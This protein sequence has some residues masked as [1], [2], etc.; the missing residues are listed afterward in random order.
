MANEF[1]GWQKHA[2]MG[3]ESTWGEG[4]SSSAGA[5]LQIPYSSFSPRTVPAVVRP[6]LFTGLR[7][8]KHSYIK[9]A[10]PGGNL[11]TGLF[12]WQDSLNVSLAEHLLEWATSG[13]NSN[14]L[15]SKWF[16]LVEDGKADKK[17]HGCR[18]SALTISGDVGSDFITASLDFSAKE[19]LSLA[20]S[21]AIDETIEDPGPMFFEDIVFTLD[22]V[23]T[24]LL[25]FS[26]VVNNN[27]D[28]SHTNSY[29][30]TLIL[31]G[32]RTVQS[33]FTIFKNADTYDAYLRNAAPA[34]VAA[35]LV[36]KGLHN[37]TGLTGDYTTVTIA[38]DRLKWVNTEDQD[39]SARNS[40]VKTL[41]SYDTLKPETTDN[42]I[43]ITYGEAA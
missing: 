29:F 2:W 26:I 33:Q 40:V 30:P 27:L 19:E 42:D 14:T 7:Q 4:E 41:I 34:D 5:I 3:P 28:V 43:D 20:A 36:L 39:G 21:E 23:V 15:D 13:D 11:T 35:T 31:A 17:F 12:A 10:T 24:Q 6:D 16:E 38:M 25:S 22:S 32:E 9:N 37:G 1:V 18:P 8:R